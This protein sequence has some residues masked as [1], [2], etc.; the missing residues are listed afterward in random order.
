MNLKVGDHQKIS[1]S[2]ISKI[3]KFFSWLSKPTLSL[4]H[5]SNSILLLIQNRRQTSSLFSINIFWT[6]KYR[7]ANHQ[8][9]VQFW[10]SAEDDEEHRLQES[11]QTS[12]DKK[13]WKWVKSKNT[14]TFRTLWW[15]G[16]PSFRYWCCY[17]GNAGERWRRKSQK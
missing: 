15:R 11:S 3:T 17:E 7:E 10:T 5:L 13:K 4:T 12:D 9:Q 2:S 8:T 14:L 16:H 1:I 6:L